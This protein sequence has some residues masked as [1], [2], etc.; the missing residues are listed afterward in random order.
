[1][2]ARDGAACARALGRLRHDVDHGRNVLPALVESARAGATVGEMC[3]TFRQAFGEFRSRRRG[4][5]L[6]SGLRVLDLT[7]FVSGSQA[8]MLLA[9]MGA[10]VIKI[11]VPPGIRTGGRAPSASAGSRRCSWR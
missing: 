11:E 2:A 1:V 10:D 3:E 6:L 9:A 8:T 5:R 4:D 7:R